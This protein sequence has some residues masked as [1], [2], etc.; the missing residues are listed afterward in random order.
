M[1]H[2]VMLPTVPPIT[3]P[4]PRSGP[5][6]VKR[7][8]NRKL[9]DTQARRYVTLEHLARL[10]GTGEEVRVTDQRT[11]EDLTTLMLAQVVLEGIRT[12]TW[13]IPG[14]A[15]ARLIRLGGRAAG[16][17]WM[18]PQE[19]TRR[20]RQETE[21]IVG[22]LLGRLSLE[23]AV[24][25]RQ[26]LTGAVQRIVSEAQHGL[27]ERVRGLL[28]RLEGE[29]GAHPL[30]AAVRTRLL[31][32][33]EPASPTHPRAGRRHTTTRKRTSGAR[34]AAHMKVRR[35]GPEPRARTPRKARTRRKR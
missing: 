4:R 32:P 20:A 15:L 22:R 35:A 23:D 18:S 31:S 16:A 27:E 1:T 34:P 25:L 17:A 10:V 26:D 28:D 5:R 8:E 29:S 19:A 9:Y 13:R 11:G 24:A 33:A 6:L 7:Y 3:K 12:R 14:Q 30:L 2:C 21:R